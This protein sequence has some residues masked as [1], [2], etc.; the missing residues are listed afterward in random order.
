MAT[1]QRLVLSVMQ[2]ENIGAV[3]T[4][5]FGWVFPCRIRDNAKIAESVLKALCPPKTLTQH[6]IETLTEW[7]SLLQDII[8]ANNRNDPAETWSE[9]K[10]SNRLGVALEYLHQRKAR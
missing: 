5:D 4:L 7:R 8:M 2:E 9:Q 10:L 1:I 3:L 6:L